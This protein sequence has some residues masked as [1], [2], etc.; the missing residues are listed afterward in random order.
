MIIDTHPTM[1]EPD[2]EQ[3]PRWATQH[4]F[5]PNSEGYFGHGVELRTK[6]SFNSWSYS[7]TMPSGLYLPIGIDWRTTLR[8]RPTAT[9]LP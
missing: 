7:L 5:S 8:R 6:H 2:W 9:P 4:F 1:P 3:A